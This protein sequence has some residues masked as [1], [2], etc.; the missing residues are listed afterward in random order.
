MACRDGGER[1]EKLT[2]LSVLGGDEGLD[3]RCE[4]EI[5]RR[6][7]ADVVTPKVQRDPSPLD[8]HV[9]MVLLRL[10]HPGQPVNKPDRRDEIRE[11]IRPAQ[12]AVVE[13][14][15]GDGRQPLEDHMSCKS[16]LTWC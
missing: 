14:P 13:R 12:L 3:G 6:D 7:P 16:S 9:G 1:K 11:R 2:R 15:V 8:S 4:P 5:A 10:G